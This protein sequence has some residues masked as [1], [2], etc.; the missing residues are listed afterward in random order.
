MQRAL[1]RVGGAAPDARVHEVAA[2][3]L[4][5]EA[6][7]VAG[8]PLGGLDA[9]RACA[10]EQRRRVVA[11]V[12]DQRGRAAPDAA[13]RGAAPGERDECVGG[14][15]LP[16]E[17]DAGRLVGGALVRGDAPDR[18]L[19]R[20]ALLERQPAAERELALATRPRHAQRATLIER[21]IVGHHRRRERAGGERDRA[22]RLADRDAR[23]LGVARG[24][25]EL[26][27]GCD[28]I[29]RQRARAQRVVERRQSRSAL[30]VRVIRAALR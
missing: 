8:E 21:L 16:L 4:D 12:H 18:L 23:Q 6:A 22:R 13:S 25:R 5:G 1:L 30:L 10:F 24:G 29:E 17:R 15:L 14:R 7:R 9:D 19:E 20:R 27:R 11:D 2:V 3:G 28:L 26:G